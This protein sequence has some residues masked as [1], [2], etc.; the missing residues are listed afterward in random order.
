MVK[1]ESNTSSAAVFTEPLT[2]LTPAS[3]D[4]I[5]FGA[6]P[7]DCLSGKVHDNHPEIAKWIEAMT[8]GHEVESAATE[9]FVGAC[10]DNDD[11]SIY[12]VGDYCSMT[13][14]D[15]EHHF[16][17]R[18][19]RGRSVQF[20]ILSFARGYRVRLRGYALYIRSQAPQEVEG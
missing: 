10:A 6:I 9:V 12:P 17:L 20:R 2:V 13:E 11:P 15:G 16:W 1:V 14:S 3:G 8:L 5:V 18:T 19:A 4:L 7:L